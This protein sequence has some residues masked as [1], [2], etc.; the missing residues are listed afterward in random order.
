MYEQEKAGAPPLM[1]YRPTLVEVSMGTRRQA[2][3]PMV[4]ALIAS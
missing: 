2:E 1:T 3:H 4:V